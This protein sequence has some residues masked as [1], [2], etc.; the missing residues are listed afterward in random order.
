[1]KQRL[2]A[3]LL[4][5]LVLLSA[6]S[7]LALPVSAQDMPYATNRVFDRA[8][9][10]SDNEIDELGK[11][12][13]DIRAQYPI[14]IVLLTVQSLDGKSAQDYADDF[15]DGVSESSDGVLFLWAVDSRDCYISTSGS[16]IGTLT[17]SRLND[18]FDHITDDM[19][20][21]RLSDAMQLF[22]DDLAMYV[23]TDAASTPSDGTNTDDTTRVVRVIDGTGLLSATE[24]QELEDKIHYIRS[25]Y[26]FDV[27][28]LIVS[29]L[30]C[31]TAQDVAD[32]YYDY[33]GYGFG[34]NHDGA[35]FLWAVDTRDCYISTCGSG[36][37]VITDRRLDDIFDDIADDMR[38]DRL[39]AAVD[40]FLGDLEVYL[41]DYNGTSGTRFFNKN[42]F[43]LFFVLG[44]AISL[45]TTYSIRR[46]MNTARRQ[47]LARAYVR[48]GSF[49]LTTQ[50]DLFLYVTRTRTRV[51]S[52]SSGG[53]SSTHT[54]SSGRSHGGGGRRF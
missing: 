9:L 26:S 12:I 18:I 45:I 15:Y 25:T 52:S 40:R 47:A 51:Q 32:D 36:I 19:K 41:D 4:A 28:I 2:F 17:D 24:K 34:E 22:L 27:V 13:A 42:V 16:V 10:L 3:P 30:G 6:L 53:G 8:E 44:I 21:D 39:Y 35:L 5:L 20:A 14:D 23:Q 50:S 29:D 33:N 11:A 31:Q 46:G 48:P 38:A 43:G 7:C 37:K 49:K 1:M 54:S